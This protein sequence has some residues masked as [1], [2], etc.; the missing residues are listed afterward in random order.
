MK[1]NEVEACVGITKKNIR[2]Y[3]AEGLLTPRRNSDNGYREYGEVEVRILKQIKLLR[4]LGFPLEDIRQMQNGIL[5]VSDGMERHRVILG[6]EKKN[7][8]QSLALCN[9]LSRENMKLEDLDVDIILTQI[10]SMESDGTTF[11]NKYEKDRKINIATA[12]V[13]SLLVILSMTGMSGFIIWDVFHTG[14]TPV[15]LLIMVLVISMA[16]I[17]AVMLVLSMRIKEIERGEIEEA[18]RY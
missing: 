18:R 11:Q 3:E 5:T 4:K 12:I 6:R 9:E 13:I 2:F 10:T 15:T 1:I 14:D 7:I 8:E 16:I 17:L